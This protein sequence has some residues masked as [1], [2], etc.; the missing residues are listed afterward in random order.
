MLIIKKLRLQRGWSQAEL[1]LSEVVIIMFFV[2]IRASY[3][4]IHRVHGLELF[5][6]S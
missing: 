4:R 2:I 3:I 5:L 6:F 1:A